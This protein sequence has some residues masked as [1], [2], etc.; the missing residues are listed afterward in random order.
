LFKKNLPL[1]I[2]LLVAFE[3]RYA[4]KGCFPD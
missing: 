4:Y 3:H 2:S 1:P